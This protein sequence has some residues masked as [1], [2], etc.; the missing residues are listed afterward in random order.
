MGLTFVYKRPRALLRIRPEYKEDDFDLYVKDNL[1]YIKLNA[2]NR[3]YIWAIH[4]I[5]VTSVLDYKNKFIEDYYEVYQRGGCPVYLDSMW[6]L[7]VPSRIGYALK[8]LGYIERVGYMQQ[9]F[10]E[11]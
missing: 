10:K 9:I 8:E 4:D 3:K 5:T 1:V 7:K 6:L 2:L 11:V